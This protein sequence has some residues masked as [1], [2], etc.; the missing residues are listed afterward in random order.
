MIPYQLPVPPS[1]CCPVGSRLARALR[2]PSGFRSGACVHRI[3]IISPDDDFAGDASGLQIEKVC[4]SI[5]CH[6]NGNA[7]EQRP[8]VLASE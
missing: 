7:I 2:L 3:P 6:A 5:T 4:V 8:S 1:C